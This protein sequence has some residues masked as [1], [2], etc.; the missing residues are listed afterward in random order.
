MTRI[1]AG[2]KVGSKAD[3]GQVR[4]AFLTYSKKASM[5]SCPLPS[6]P[7]IKYRTG[8]RVSL[9]PPDPISLRQLPSPPV[10]SHFLF[11]KSLILHVLSVHSNKMAQKIA[12]MRGGGNAEHSVKELTR[13]DN[14][15]HV[16]LAGFRTNRG[17]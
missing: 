3:P 15:A 11:A 9:R 14:I 13:G 2:R 1:S 7:A 5:K 17:H 12:R 8:N 4:L 16:V 6:T 10:F